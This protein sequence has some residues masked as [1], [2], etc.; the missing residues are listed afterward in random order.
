MRATPSPSI[1]F[2]HPLSPSH[3]I[4]PLS[5]C[6]LLACFSLLFFTVPAAS[7]AEVRERLSPRDVSNHLGLELSMSAR[8]QVRRNAR[9]AGRG[10]GHTVCKLSLLQS[11]DY[12]SE[13]RTTTPLD[14]CWRYVADFNLHLNRLLDKIPTIGG[15]ASCIVR[16][17]DHISTPSYPFRGYTAESKLPLCTLVSK[18]TS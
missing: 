17:E 16:S 7:L 12:T 13:P 2:P 3:S 8:G 18:T 5:P 1:P 6:C 15:T 11:V 9:R 14:P 10:V 4:T